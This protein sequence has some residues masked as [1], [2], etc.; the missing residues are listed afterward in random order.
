MKENGGRDAKRTNQLFKRKLNF[1][2]ILFRRYIIQKKLSQTLLRYN[3]LSTQDWEDNATTATH[4]ACFCW[5]SKGIFQERTSALCLKVLLMSDTP[6]LRYYHC[7]N[8]IYI[9]SSAV[10]PLFPAYSYIRKYKLGIRWTAGY[11]S[12]IWE[13][14]R[15]HPDWSGCFCFFLII[16]GTEQS[17]CRSL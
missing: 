12:A 15:K 2:K 4:A 10:T 1:W 11:P 9:S 7:Q 17:S 6:S 14:K 13:P 16:I 8:K 3:C 5:C